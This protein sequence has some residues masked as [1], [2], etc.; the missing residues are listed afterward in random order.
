MLGTSLIFLS[1][2]KGKKMIK[3][4]KAFLALSVLFLAHEASALIDMNYWVDKEYSHVIITYDE[5][6]SDDQ[7][8]SFYKQ[9]QRPEQSTSG[10]K[11]KEFASSTGLLRIKCS[12]F[13]NQTSKIK[14]SCEFEIKEGSTEHSGSW[15]YPAMGYDTP[16][17]GL[18]LYKPDSLE[19]EGVFPKNQ[20][21]RIS[22]VMFNSLRDETV[23]PAGVL[24]VKVNGQH[25]EY[26]KLETEYR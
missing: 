13:S 9:M 3:L 15:I 25:S 11:Y 14:H 7:V 20:Y 19:L 22:F 2:L 12:K 1:E 8:E 10:N 5:S 17:V 23:V 18:G 6:G 21:G 24:S 16:V 4:R 26:I